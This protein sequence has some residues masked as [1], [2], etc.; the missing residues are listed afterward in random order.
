[1]DRI[2]KSGHEFDHNSDHNFDRNFDHNFSR[3]DLRLNLTRWVLGLKLDLIEKSHG[4]HGPRVGFGPILWSQSG[5]YSDR[6]VD[7]GLQVGSWP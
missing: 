5:Q 7:L 3:L 6:K 2:A 1:M 4:F